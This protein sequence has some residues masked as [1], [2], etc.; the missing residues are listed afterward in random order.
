MESTVNPLFGSTMT[1]MA[2]SLPQSTGTPEGTPTNQAPSPLTKE[3]S[4]TN[5]EEKQEEEAFGFQEEE[6][7]GFPE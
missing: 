5:E 6:A 1:G 7:F 3:S 2:A 4:K